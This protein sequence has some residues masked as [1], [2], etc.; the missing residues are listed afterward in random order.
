MK[1]NLL[2]FSLIDSAFAVIFKKYLSH[3]R[4]KSYFK[5]VMVFKPAQN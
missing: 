1:S 4:H 2:I 3:P 5:K